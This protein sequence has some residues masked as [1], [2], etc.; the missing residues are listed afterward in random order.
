MCVDVYNLSQ[1][2][3]YEYKGQK[4]HPCHPYCRTLV[5]KPG[6]HPLSGGPNTSSFVVFIINYIADVWIGASMNIVLDKWC[7]EI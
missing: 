2:H 5:L 4:C 6:A 3:S 1:F 7:L